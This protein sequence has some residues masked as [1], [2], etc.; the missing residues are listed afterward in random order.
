MNNLTATELKTLNQVSQLRN[1]TVLLGALVQSLIDRV[2]A[3]E[4]PVNAVSAAND[5]EITGV[6]THLETVT[7]GED[8][9]EFCALATPVPSNPEYIPVDI[10][11]DVVHASVALTM[12]VQPIAG[13]KVTIGTKEYTFVPVGTDTADGEVSV[14]TDLA[15]AKLAL[16]AAINGTDGISDPHELV[17]AAAF[18]ANICTIT[19][20]VGGT[21]GNTIASTETFT[22]GSNLFA[23]T[24]L[25]GGV[26]CSAANAGDA[27]A[28][29]IMA[30]ATEPVEAT[31]D[32]GTVTIYA[33]SGGVAG[34]EI[35]VEE[36]MTN[37]AFATA[38]GFLDG[39][40]DGTIGYAGQIL[41]D[42]T[43]FYMCIADNPVSGSNW[44]RTA[45]GES[46]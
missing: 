36:D 2:G 14:G 33:V 41:V 8:V 26:N 22:S 12:A 9:Y 7:V 32:N 6:V 39:G 3:E 46:F 30:S 34:N 35:S 23:T 45:I 18:I 21:I 38:G 24:T 4:T 17:S 37:G 15:A 40:V 5:L 31:A 25:L 42:E 11:A 13:D 16:V 28:D 44:R 20:L 43:Y 27:L 29:T 10:D 19:A 1:R